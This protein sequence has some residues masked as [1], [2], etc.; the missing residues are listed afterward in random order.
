MLISLTDI[1]E[2]ATAVWLGRVTRCLALG[3]DALEAEILG[4]Y[5]RGLKSRPPVPFAPV[6]VASL[7]AASCPYCAYRAGSG[8]TR[9][10]LTD[11]QVLQEMQYLRGL[12]YGEVYVLSGSTHPDLVYRWAK[13]GVV[14]AVQAGLW[15]VIEVSTLYPRH[16]RTLQRLVRGSGWRALVGRGR[17]SLF[18]ETYDEA[19]YYRLHGQDRWKRDPD[20]R[21]IQHEWAAR[22]GWPELG[23]G[24]LLGLHE[25]LAMELSCLL[26]HAELVRER[27]KVRRVAIS[28]P[29]LQSGTGVQLRRRCSDSEFLTS[30]LTLRLLAPRALLVLTARESVAIRNRLWPYTN[31]WGVAGSTEPGGYTVY[32]SDPEGAMPDGQFDLHDRRS[33][34]AIR[35]ELDPD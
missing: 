18:Q 15:P 6:Y 5:G 9:R 25:D 34:K 3:A 26:A 1:H 23:L 20:L 2:R 13:R 30:M 31:S 22:A 29:R 11:A 12:G 35:S 14:A 4:L 32:P 17:H 21:L 28:L 7:C 8:I 33:W 24:A 10:E 16:L 27:L 19:A